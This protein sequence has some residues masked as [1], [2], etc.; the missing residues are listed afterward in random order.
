[1]FVDIAVSKF[2]PITRKIIAKPDTTII[3]ENQMILVVGPTKIR[4]FYLCMDF[5]MASPPPPMIIFRGIRH[6]IYSA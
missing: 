1:M 3:Q 6:G 2:T 4:E 5:C